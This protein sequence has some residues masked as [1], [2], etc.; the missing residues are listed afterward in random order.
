M[1][2]KKSITP[3]VLF[4]VFTSI[5]AASYGIFSNDGAGQY[6]Y[7]SI[8]GEKITVYGIGL[9]KHMSADVAIQG[10]AQDYITLFVGVPLLLIS[11]LFARKNSIRGMFLLSGILGYFLVTYLFYLTMGMYNELFLLYA[12]LL[13]VSFFSFVLVLLSYD[14]Y[15]IK[16]IFTS[17]RLMKNA[18]IF[19]I[20]NASLVAL[21][22]LSIVVP[23]LID[24]SI[25][26]NGLQ[27]YTTLIVQGLDLGLLLP[28]GALVG[29]LAIKKNIYGYLFAPIYMIFLSLLM[30]ALISK[31][32]FMAFAGENVVPVIFIMPTIA[33]ISITFSILL[34]KKI[35]IADRY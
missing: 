17:G 34:L 31:I 21:L 33:L 26:P 24:G 19:L 13:G 1:K 32:I 4:T 8:R 16:E 10:I 28:A 11:L 35:R 18:G 30:T 14:I 3:L 23:P 2:N 27:H 6:V 7:E 25:Y 9:Y 12:F 15:K 20:V 29:V 22:W 5:I